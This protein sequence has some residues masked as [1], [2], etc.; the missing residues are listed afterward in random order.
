MNLHGILNKGQGRR[1]LGVG[2]IMARTA[3]T[4][5]KIGA[6]A[7]A[8]GMMLGGAVAVASSA[9]AH[10]PSVTTTCEALTVNLTNYQIDPGHAETFTTV[11]H[12]AVTHTMWR[13]DKN[14]QY[15]GDSIWVN[16]NTFLYV[17]N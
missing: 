17:Q 11:H 14:G 9:S 10:S 16:N 12:D 15:L 8:T 13:Y 2:A 3:G 7:V 1:L 5:K 6:I 4:S